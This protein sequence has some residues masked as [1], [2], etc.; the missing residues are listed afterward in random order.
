MWC[1]FCIQK[2]ADTAEA[3]LAKLSVP[4]PGGKVCIQ[5]NLIAF[6]EVASVGKI[7]IIIRFTVKPVKLWVRACLLYCYQTEVRWNYKL[8]ESELVATFC[9]QTRKQHTC[10]MAFSSTVKINPKFYSV[11]NHIVVIFYFKVSEC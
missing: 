9:L 8:E 7:D 10:S 3:R 4:L 11:G 5:T 2:K 1:W 6:F